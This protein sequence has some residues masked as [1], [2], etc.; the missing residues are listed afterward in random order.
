LNRVTK[1]LKETLCKS[2]EDDKEAS[3]TPAGSG[4]EAS[5]K[6]AKN[7]QKASKKTAKDDKEPS[8]IKKWRR[9][10]DFFTCDGTEA[11]FGAGNLSLSVG[12]L[13]PGHQVCIS[14]ICG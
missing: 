6:T 13:N 7:N 9:A 11:E 8:K 4:A 2:V 5:K 3:E 14:T 12:V 10:A 1:G